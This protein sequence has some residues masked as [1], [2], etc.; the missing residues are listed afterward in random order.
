MDPSPLASLTTDTPTVRVAIVCGAPETTDL[1]NS[2]EALLAEAKG[3][4]FSRYEYHAS[5]GLKRYRGCSRD[6]DI[7]AA[8]LGAFHGTETELF[9]AALQRVF[10]D[11]SV[12]IT[13]TRPDTFDF[14]RV[15]EM[16]ASD[17]LLPPLRRSELLPPVMR[18][19]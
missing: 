11:R 5:G 13:T 16:G 14:F 3:F 4:T 6:P 17:F 9:L 7:V 8:T 18:P 15:L 1:A 2:L 19:G 12:L 10:P